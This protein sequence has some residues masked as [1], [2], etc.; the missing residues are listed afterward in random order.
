MGVLDSILKPSR[1][2]GIRGYSGARPDVVRMI[3]A[4]PRRVLDV[5]CGAGMTAALIAARYPEA[6]TE[7]KT[8]MAGTL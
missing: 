3:A 6:E 7:I 4:P 5:G 2:N 8:E 1:P